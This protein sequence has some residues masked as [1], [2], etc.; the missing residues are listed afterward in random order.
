MA[1][2]DIALDED[3]FIREPQFVPRGALVLPGSVPANFSP[4]S[5]CRSRRQPGLELGSW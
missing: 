1:P 3:A 5:H 4:R 2:G